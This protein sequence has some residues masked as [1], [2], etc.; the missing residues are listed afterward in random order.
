MSFAAD[1]PAKISVLQEKEQDSPGNEVASGLSST[2]SST[3]SA[4]RGSSS[5]I[6]A[7]FALADW[8]PSSGASLRSGMM[9][10]GTV[11]PLQ[12]LARLTAGT[13]SGLLPTPSGVGSGRKNHV[14]GRL[15]EWGGE[16]QPFPWDRGWESALREFRGMDDGLSYGVD[17]VDTLRN[18]V[19]PQIPEIIGRAILS[20][21]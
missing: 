5:K 10:S 21:N 6:P 16:F 17:R 13:G 14:M 1:F 2:G 15:D 20:C 11:Y 9:R 8:I 19:V 4:R 18:A 7:P 3:R 12:P